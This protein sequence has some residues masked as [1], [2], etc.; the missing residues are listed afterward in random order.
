[1]ITK[2]YKYSLWIKQ[3]DNHRKRCVLSTLKQQSDTVEV[4]EEESE[5][6]VKWSENDPNKHEKE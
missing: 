5:V 2:R 4:E 1:M 6:N 3:L